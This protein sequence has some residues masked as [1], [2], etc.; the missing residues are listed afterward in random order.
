MNEAEFDSFAEEYR[1]LHRENIKASGEAPEFFA[2][3][4]VA[5]IAREVVQG[6]IPVP[7]RILDFGAGIGLSVPYFRRYFPSAKITCLDVSRKSLEL[8]EK[9]HGDAAQFVHFDGRRANFDSGSFDL[10]FAACV[11]HH[12]PADMH[13][14]LLQ[15]IR[16]LLT[17]RGILV[18]F[19]HNPFNPF[20]VRAVNT[21]ELD[22]NAVLLK[23]GT[24]AKSAVAA[25]FRSPRA[26]FRLFFPGALRAFRPLERWLEWVPIGAQYSLWCRSA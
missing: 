5:D 23:S 11:F 14:P 3:Y 16:R 26:R 25:G 10:A 9:I 1:R 2:E 22:A 15:D 19:E 13:V 4:K 18:I 7:S 8:G 12:I 24:I 21:C 20:T 17:P 6:S